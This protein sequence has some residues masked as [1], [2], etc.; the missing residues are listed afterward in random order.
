MVTYNKE[1][2]DNTD[3]NH[4]PDTLLSDD[5]Y[6]S[7]INAQLEKNISLQV[8]TVIDC[9]YAGCLIDSAKQA[10]KFLDRHIIFCAVSS[11]LAARGPEKSASFFTG[12]FCRAAK[13]TKTYLELKN[14]LLATSGSYTPAI[15]F[16][17]SLNDIL[18]P[19]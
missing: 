9:C 11:R 1:Y 19:L 2:F 10:D 5:N 17:T 8:I 6:I 16:A 15:Y 14:K 7:A 12:N 3:I 4:P 18:H 13:E